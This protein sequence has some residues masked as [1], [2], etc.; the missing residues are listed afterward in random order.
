MIADLLELE[1]VGED[2]SLALDCR[3]LACRLVQRLAEFLNRPGVEKRLFARECSRHIELGLIRQIGDNRLVRLQAAQ[4]EWTRQTPH[5]GIVLTLIRRLSE[6]REA[7]EESRI[8]KIKNAPEIGQPIL[9]R[10]TRQGETTRRS[11]RSHGL[12]LARTGVLD[13]LRLVRDHRMKRQFREFLQP[14]KLSVGRQHQIIARHVV[15][16]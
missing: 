6:R 3:F 12:A 10:R 7:A 15:L 5:D 13:R 2:Q 8:H 16:E 11:D 9:N 4:D 1:H 14:R